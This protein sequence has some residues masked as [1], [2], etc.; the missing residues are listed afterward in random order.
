MKAIRRGENKNKKPGKN[1][2]NQR[3]ELEKMIKTNDAVLS[4]EK[5]RLGN[6]N[7]SQRC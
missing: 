4:D 7:I 2:S 3:A 6:A 1:G 5:P